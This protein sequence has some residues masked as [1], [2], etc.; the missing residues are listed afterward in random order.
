MKTI[1]YLSVLFLTAFEIFNVYFIMPMPGSQEMDS[2]GIAYFLYTYRWLFRI[3]LGAGVVIGFVKTW[4]GPRKWVRMITLI[5][6]LAAVYL[7]NFVMVADKMFLQPAE[8][9]LKNAAENEVPLDRIVLGIVHDG[10]AKAYPIEYLAYHH[11][12]QDVVGGRS[13]IVTYCS[14]C[15]TGRVFEPLVDGKPEQFR[16]VGM[17]HFNAMF[18]DETTGSWWRQVSGEAITGSLKGSKLPEFPSVQMTL[19]QWLQLYPNSLIMQPDP[20]SVS[21]YDPEARYEK[22]LSQSSLTG[23][24]PASWQKKSWVVGIALETESKAYDWNDLEQKRIINDQIGET[25]IMLVLSEDLQSFAAF[26]RPDKEIATIQGDTIFVCNRKYNL[27]GVNYED[28]TDV[29]KRV[30]AYQEFWHSWQTF[31]PATGRYAEN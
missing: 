9:I 20:A 17:D 19:Q 14:V 27:A 31:H 22:G 3:L 23:T 13:V 21:N 16:L 29:L 15:R 8:L 6:M 10:E 4:N 28:N 1:F 5:P 30:P 2:I 25:A 18:E 12:V 7:F 24:D 11:Q 26:Q